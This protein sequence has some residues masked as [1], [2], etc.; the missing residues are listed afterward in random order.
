MITILVD[1]IVLPR[2][3]VGSVTW[4]PT[5]YLSICF[6]RHGK[7][8][9]SN[10]V[11]LD[12]DSFLTEQ[13]ENDIHIPIQQTLELGATLYKEKNSVYQEKVTSLVLRRNIKKS[14]TS[15]DLG[16][17]DIQMH[18]LA[19]EFDAS[20][21]GHQ[22]IIEARLEGL[23]GGSLRLIAQA[24]S[25]DNSS[26][27]ASSVGFT[28][29]SESLISDITD[30]DGNTG[31]GNNSAN[32]SD[33]NAAMLADNNR[34]KSVANSNSNSP[35]D[36]PRPPLQRRASTGGRI[37]PV[38]TFD[39]SSLNNAP[40]NTNKQFTFGNTTITRN[41]AL[42]KSSS[43]GAAQLKASTPEPSA[44]PL[45]PVSSA[46]A[47]VS[48]H[49]HP[50][51]HA[52]AS[53]SSHSNSAGKSH[54][55]PEEEEEP[56]HHPAFASLNEII[57][58]RDERIKQLEE[59]LQKHYNSYQ[60]EKEHLE[61]EIRLLSLPGGPSRIPASSGAD[62]H[63]SSDDSIDMSADGNQVNRSKYQHLMFEK[64]FLSK[65]LDLSNVLREEY[66]KAR[67]AEKEEGSK[68][69]AN[70]VNLEAKKGKAEEEYCQVTIEFID[71]KEEEANNILDLELAVK[72]SVA[73][74]K[75]LLELS[76]KLAQLEI[77][78]IKY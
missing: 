55:N 51:T 66:E 3:L 34:P 9:T 46:P 30:L 10:E 29:D 59:S 68:L 42:K 5:T 74:R 54:I 58:T 19:A 70:L 12:K 37:E 44:P 43:V 13:L 41:E 40:T 36:V 8:V 71:H 18:A 65:E 26:L 11:A 47:P 45:D 48:A 28:D 56:F 72:K 73:L 77:G 52:A 78:L 50:V 75:E 2:P 67:D 25:S 21:P 33:L 49:N 60:S 35:A 38:R 4:E 20:P 16:H 27:F 17:Y 7:V 31:L 24:G 69:A 76:E 15:K 14:K 63:Q 61:S 23:P 57:D 6:E 22:K 32:N 53:I 39:G 1:E 64:H 62:G